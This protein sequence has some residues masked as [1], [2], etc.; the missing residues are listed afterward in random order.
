MPNQKINILESNGTGKRKNVFIYLFNMK[1]LMYWRRDT[2]EI[3][4]SAENATDFD[5]EPI[6]IKFHTLSIMDGI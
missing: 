1:C 2:W 6:V 4:L 3:T 5:R